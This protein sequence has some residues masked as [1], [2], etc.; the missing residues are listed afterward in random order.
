MASN[1]KRDILGQERSAEEEKR[2]LRE[3]LARQQAQEE[4]NRRAREEQERRRREQEEADRRRREYEARRARERE[5]RERQEREEAE[6]QARFQRELAR[7]MRIKQAKKLNTLLSLFIVISVALLALSIVSYFNIQ[8]LIVFKVCLVCEIIAAVLSIALLYRDAE[9]RGSTTVKYIYAVLIVAHI[10]CATML[11]CQGRFNVEKVITDDNG[12]VY[13]VVDGEYYLYSC[14]KEMPELVISELSDNIVGISSAGLKEKDSV[15]TLVV[16]VPKFTVRRKAFADCNKLTKVLFTGSDYAGDYVIQG[17]AFKNC[18]K[19]EYVLF[20]NG[21]YTLA[22]SAL[23]QNCAKL[24]NIHLKNGTFSAAGSGKILQGLGDIAVHLDNATTDI[25]FDGA[26]K[27]TIVVYAGTTGIGTSRPDVL[28]FQ[29]GFDFENWTDTRS[30]GDVAPPAPVIYLPTS[31][32][33]IPGRLFGSDSTAYHVYYQGSAASWSNVYVEET[34]GW[35]FGSN[36]NYGR[37]LT[38]MHYESN[39]QYWDMY[40]FGGN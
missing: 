11:V 18:D 2:A 34:G 23:F 9:K 32:S 40:F 6:R 38:I 16:D 39:C 35:I 24:D 30:S 20:D 19:L 29:N 31:V 26:D 22:T 28:V 37:N 8:M 1:P 15:E 14:G 36:S 4:A 17:R 25:R 21:T 3:E 7:K 10:L 13:E 5:E 27:L 33:S 12:C